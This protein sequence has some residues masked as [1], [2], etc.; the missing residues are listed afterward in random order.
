MTE[1]E[2]Q[3]F[4]IFIIGTKIQISAAPVLFDPQLLAKSQAIA[5]PE[6]LADGVRLVLKREW[7]PPYEEVGKA[8]RVSRAEFDASV[9]AG[10]DPAT[11]GMEGQVSWRGDT[12]RLAAQLRRWADAGASHVAVNTMGAG[13]ESVDAHLAVLTMAAEVAAEVAGA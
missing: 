10:R 12:G 11:I 9:A 8:L 4:M 13:L 7:N 2:R 5:W 6:G 3:L 1:P